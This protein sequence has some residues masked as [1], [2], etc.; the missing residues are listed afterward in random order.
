MVYQKKLVVDSSV[1]TEP[2]QGLVNF[3]VV[4][5]VFGYNPRE[6]REINP[7]VVPPDR[8]GYRNKVVVGG[9]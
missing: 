7:Q 2:K 5:Y 8:T 6:I 1:T 3:Y 9:A 4:T